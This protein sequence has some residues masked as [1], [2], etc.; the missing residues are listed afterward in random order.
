MMK[1]YWWFR[2]HSI[3]GM[4]RPGFNGVR[5]L[6]LPFDEAVVVGWLGRYSS[7]TASLTAF[8]SH[9]QSYVPKIFRFHNQD[10][11][12]GSRVIEKFADLN[13]LREVLTLLNDRTQILAHYDVAHD[14]LYF[15]INQDR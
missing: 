9:L 11:E 5:W 3:A 2:E 1:A 12:S 13:Y 10:L 14:F 4:A 7:G 15:E 6:D 8:R